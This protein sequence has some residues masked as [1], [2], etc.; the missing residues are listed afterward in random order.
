MLFPIEE[1]HLARVQAL[2]MKGNV[3][4]NYIPILFQYVVL[5]K[6]ILRHLKLFQPKLHGL[7]SKVCLNS[8]R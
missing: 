1:I 4:K 8:N 5:L 3:F 7:I 6:V 2:V